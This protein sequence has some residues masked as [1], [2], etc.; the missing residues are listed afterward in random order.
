MQVTPLVKEAK[1]QELNPDERNCLYRKHDR[2]FVRSTPKVVH[3]MEKV[4]G[5]AAMYNSTWTYSLLQ[6]Y[7]QSG[8]MFDCKLAAAATAMFAVEYIHKSCLPW[9]YP[10]VLSKYSQEGQ[11]K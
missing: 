5:E 9:N 8:C 4:D 6:D 1:L 3:L 10:M 2:Q 11:G 7:S